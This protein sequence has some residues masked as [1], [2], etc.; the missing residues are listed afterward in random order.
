MEFETWRGQ[1]RSSI[2]GERTSHRATIAPNNLGFGI[3]SGFKL[4]FNGTHAANMF[5]EFFFGMSVSLI[6]GP[7]GFAQ[8]ME[9]T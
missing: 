5:F 3:A 7:G 6:D 1:R 9:V 8:V 4:T 2:I